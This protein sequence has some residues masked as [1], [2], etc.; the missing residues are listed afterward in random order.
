MKS[1]ICGVLLGLF[2]LHSRGY[3]H[4]DIR[5][6]NVIQ[7]ENREW[8]LIDLEH[9]GKA[10]PVAY[11]LAHWPSQDNDGDVYSYT[12]KCDLYLVG[13]LMDDCSVSLDESGKAFKDHILEMKR[14]STAQTLL[15]HAWIKTN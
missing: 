15:K 9:A 4:H 3:V 10:G 8:I 7:L 5:W 1:A 2:G 13:K 14:N 12:F 6:N 11:K